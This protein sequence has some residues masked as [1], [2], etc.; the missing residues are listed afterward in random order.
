[1]ERYKKNRD[2]LKA[3]FQVLD[4]I[5]TDAQKRISKPS[6]E[7][8]YK[9]DNKI[10]EL[11]KVNKD[12][13]LKDNVLDCINDRRS[14][15]KYSNESIK[16]EELSFLLWSTQGVQKVIGDNASTLRTVPSGG[17]SHTFE[18]Y[19]IINNVDNLEKGIYRYLP[20]EHK[21]LFM[22]EIMI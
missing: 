6:I 21:L 19:L 17:A 14:I 13:L 10:I 7:K 8:N 3:N 20:L 11:P 12:V 4:E 15:R 5:K 16:L 22:Y 9:K 2:F 18:T 1:M